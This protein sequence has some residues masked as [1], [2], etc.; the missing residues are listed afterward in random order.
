[1]RTIVVG[2]NHAGTSAIRTLLSQNPK[3]DVVAFDRNSNISFLGCGIALTV[4]GVVKNTNDLFYSSPEQL[5]SMGAKIYMEHDVVK[6]DRKEKAVFVKELSTGKITAW[7]YDNLIYAAGSW[8]IDMKIK[9]Q[10]LENVEICKI[11]QH[12]LK[13][14]E[15]A[16]DPNIKS[17]TVVG[18]GYIGI[19][20][21]E[22][23][24]QKGK[25]VNLIDFQG[26]VLA[27]Y[28]DK[29]FT[30]I[31]EAEMKKEGVN[32]YL[33][34]AVTEYIGSNGKV[35]GLKT[36]NGL[37]LQSDLIIQCVG[38][39]PNHA[40][41]PDLEK[42]KNGALIINSKA[43]TSDPNIYAIGDCVA[44]YD[45]ATKT[46]RNI[47]LATN[48]VKTGIVAAS[49]INGA[50]IVQLDS[51]VGTNALC[52]FNHKFASTGVSEE[53]A[54]KFGLKVKS[55]YYED[56]DRPEWM[57]T[58]QK[59]A[60]KIVYEED[61]MRIVGAQILSFG[62]SNHSEWIFSLSLAIQKGLSLLDV[63]FTD[64]YFLPHLNKPFNFVLSAILKAL[65]MKYI[66]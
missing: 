14:I 65:G 4:G 28:F 17:V 42:T 58:V 43:Q 27:N 3:A 46:H 2:I 62:D 20:L 5:K 60:V 55:C 30:D 39:A 38:F 66:K 8:P 34:E 41:L 21:V 12:A 48:A 9:G 53:A 36:K 32:V 25:K 26:R 22:A 23:Y 59:V 49:Q 50:E 7:K 24:H 51:I 16:N 11:Y 45:A 44:I 63:A 31:L 56:N 54:L 19:E 47:A 29:E 57:N 35:T 37:E 13:L 52:V 64:V 18:A 10:E 61:T 1:M 33:N 40:L 6:I 15:R